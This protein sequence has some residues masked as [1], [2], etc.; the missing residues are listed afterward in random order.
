MAL[1]CTLDGLAHVVSDDAA[2]AGIIAGRGVYTAL[3][4]HGVHAA[5]MICS[6]GHPCPHCTQQV[7]EK[8]D[9]TVGAMGS[10]SRTLRG[11]FNRFLGRR[12]AATSRN[13]QQQRRRQAA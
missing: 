12:R 6:A 10:R 7:Q 1:T 9:A 4:G 8:L 5:A 11:W 13:R 2:V 3:C